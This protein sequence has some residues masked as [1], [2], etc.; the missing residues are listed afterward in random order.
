MQGARGDPEQFTSYLLGLADSDQV[1]RLAVLRLRLPARAI[2][3]CITQVLS[4]VRL[5]VG[6]LDVKQAFLTAPLL[7]N[8]VPILVRAPSIFRRHNICGERFW[9]VRNVR[10]GLV[11][12]PRSWQAHRD[13]TLEVLQVELPGG[14]FATLSQLMSDP[15]LWKIADQGKVL[16]YLAV[17]VDDVLC[18]SQTP[19]VESVL[20]AIGRQ[21]K[22]TAP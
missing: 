6:I 17:Y 5:D 10:Y 16:G 12:S 15:N 2:S 18:V 19:S 8:G 11:T 7:P 9:V 14:S 22:C 21:W 1:V 20:S 4:R 13:G 3:R